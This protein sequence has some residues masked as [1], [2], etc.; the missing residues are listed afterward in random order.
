V[1]RGEYLV[2]VMGCGDCHTPGTLS[3]AP[4]ASR[5]LSGTEYAWTGPWGT[6]YGR[7]L[8]PDSTGLAGWTEEDI[9]LAL[10]TGTRRDGSKVLPPMPWPWY[11]NLADEDARA[12]AAYLKSIPPVEHV[13]PAALP[14]GTKP[15]GAVVVFPPPSPWDMPAAAKGE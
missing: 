4:D 1:A 5:W 12:I 2:K 15:T 3:G 6:S 8:T 10:K 14:P 13:V 7:N 9:V 11:S